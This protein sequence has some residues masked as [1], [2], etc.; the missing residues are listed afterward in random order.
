MQKAKI[1][2][3]EDEPIIATD[4]RFTLEWLGYIVCGMASTG[5]DA[6]RLA[7]EMHPHLILM[8]VILRGTM[9]GVEAAELI[10]LHQDIPIVYVTANSDVA[11]LQRAKSTDPFGYVLKPIEERELHSAIEMALYRH[12]TQERLKESERWLYTVLQSI[13]EAVIAIG[14]EGNVKS[15]NSRAEGVTGWTQQEALGQK[16]SDVCKL[17]HPLPADETS[18][19]G[20]LDTIVSRDG[21]ETDI[22]ATL[23]PIRNDRGESMGTVYVFRDLTERKAAEK[24]LQQSEDSYRSLVE[25][26][27]DVVISLTPD[28]I[29]EYVSPV[30]S[31]VNGMTPEQ[32]L[33]Q[34]FADLVVQDDH[35]LVERAFAAIRSGTPERF[36]CRLLR[37]D[38]TPRFVRASLRTRR[39]GGRIVGMSGR[40]TDMTEQ[41][42][43]AQA[44]MATLRI[45]KAAQE[46]STLEDLF[47][48][49]H[50]VISELMPAENFSIALY[51]AGSE[52]TTYPYFVDEIEERP[53]P[54]KSGS[55]PATMVLRTGTSLHLDAWTFGEMVQRGEVEGGAATGTDWL[56]VPLRAAGNT[57]GALIVK[58]YKEKVCFTPHHQKLLELVSA[59][60]ALSIER[61]RAEVEMQALNRRLS[62]VL[63]MVGEG[64]TLSDE[65]G[66]LLIFNR[67]M[68]HI[69]GYS[70][71]EAAAE[72]DFHG[73]LAV[74][75][76][77]V[78]GAPRVNF[79]QPEGGAFQD[80]ELVIRS[81]SGQRRT[82]LASATSLTV[83]NTR[84][85]LSAFRDITERT[86]TEAEFHKLSSAVAQSP[87]SI[88]ITDAE[89]RIE[90]ANPRFEE[91]SGYTL[92]EV[93]G[94]NPRLLKS[95][96]TPDTLY[97]ELWQSLKAGKE[98]RGEFCNRK[99][100]GS[101][102]WEF[103]SISPVRNS[104][105][106]VTHYV[107]VKEDMTERKQI[108]QQLRSSEVQFRSI[109]ENSRDGNRLTD[110]NG[111]VLRV[112]E[113]FCR[114][115]GKTKAEMEGKTFGEIF[116]PE[117]RERA[118]ERYRQ[119]FAAREVEADF[120]RQINLW[121]GREVW[122]AVSN[123]FIDIG[124]SQTVLLSL[125]RDI[126]ERKAAEQAL[127]QHA[128]QLLDAKSK[129]EEQTRLLERQ[130]AELRLAREQALEGSRL[131][132]EFV[133]NMSHEIRT[134]MNGVIG[135][136]G[137]LLDTPLSAEQREYAHIIRTSGEALLSIINQIL[138]FSKIEAG[139]L[140]LEKIDF[141][142]RTVV[143]E[144]VDLLATKAHEKR[145]ELGSVVDV[146]VPSGLHGD[147]G[148]IRQ[149]LVNLI[150]NAIKFTE[151]GDVFVSVTMEGEQDSQAILRFAVRDTG[152]GIPSDVRERLFQPFTQADGSTTRRFGGTGLGLAISKQLVEMMGGEIGVGSRAGSGSEFWYT[153]RLEK[154]QNATPSFSLGAV[155]EGKR[156]LIVDDNDTNRRILSHQIGSWGMLYCAVP[157]SVEAL[158]ELRAAELT[159]D[160]YDIVVL[161]MEMPDMDGLTLARAITTDSELAHL[162]LVMLTSVGG[163][164]ATK[165]KEA[166]I[167]MCLS[168]PV[169]EHSLRNAL[170]S[171]YQSTEKPHVTVAQEETLAAAEPVPAR[172]LRVLVAED[173]VVNQKVAERM[174]QK[175]GCH[176]DIVSN[177]FE[178]VDALGHVPYDI[179]FMDCNMPE[180]D[181]LTATERIRATEEEGK[182]TIIVALTANAMK[183]EREKCLEVGMDD[184]LAKPVVQKSMAETI[185]RWRA[186]LVHQEPAQAEQQ[187]VTPDQQVIDRSRLDELA[188]LGDEENATWLQSIVDNFREDASSRIVKLVVAAE[189]GDSRQLEQV[190][191]ALK[192]S[193][194]NIG[195]MTMAAHAQSLQ[196]LGRSGTVHGAVDM[197]AALEREFERVKTELE[198]YVQ[199]QTETR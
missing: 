73:R 115:V 44:E 1:L 127:A 49:V 85:V 153:L 168:K 92:D 82:V 81:K 40:L 199:S 94:G 197:I 177:G 134:P 77:D 58:T 33:N 189:T 187:V 87:V 11:T 129:A 75:V 137:L 157:S 193:C 102:F 150:G 99:K 60:V 172:S 164:I 108:E 155:I 72:K 159:G 136:T 79:S 74:E 4:L 110:A 101:L 171:L 7:S 166:G 76:Q 120:E 62:T 42:Q 91:V 158:S 63:E 139:K 161:D 196:M 185:E 175:L 56:G 65:N 16:F 194:G 116:A 138:D 68:Q 191:H 163:N 20:M 25:N 46:S 47:R 90:Y 119:R 70:M 83:A 106:A 29:I 186:K 27:N 19:H 95:G 180:M 28:G 9:D 36:E 114:L 12:S 24:A 144:A 51:D 107:A 145:L 88:V 45:I 86:K 132:S 118:V 174:L 190:A 146:A 156:V 55:G 80:V 18:T 169:K 184:Y 54:G 93:R 167:A 50:T 57:I 130:A 182:H 151:K 128:A 170:I 2:I 112:N 160:G 37:A 69:T 39:E 117:N 6:V 8:D 122:F 84:L 64:I 126:T 152:I 147:P 32:V 181:G 59:Q 10:H 21:R 124:S 5:E 35:A 97:A 162:R 143:G 141:D 17:A 23:S 14:S 195:A 34:P 154:Q 48:E 198:L 105:G 38:G 31:S 15:L 149:I 43:A 192:G 53:L 96:V 121:D 98:W 71:E 131:K 22:E 188:D 109:W 67:M 13:G 100:D 52:Q 26:L 133:A 142:L 78:E 173:N 61:K 41:L 125:F 140:T 148:R 30:L 135:M 183:G 178:A 111:M 123:T 89:G 104:K 176:V 165:A 113:A 66:K 103:A 3:V 179:V